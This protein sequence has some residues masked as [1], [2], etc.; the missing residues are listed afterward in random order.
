MARI[1]RS[2][3][4]RIKQNV[5]Q[6][7]IQAIQATTPIDAAAHNATATTDDV[8]TIEAAVNATNATT[9]IEQPT[10]Q[11]DTPQA[12]KQLV[13]QQANAEAVTKAVGAKPKR[14][15]FSRLLHWLLRPFRWLGKVLGVV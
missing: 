15:F 14:C 6:Q 13:E 8:V 9:S 2:K 3:T 11:V 4:K 10:Q 7:Q 12:A 1:N 5:T